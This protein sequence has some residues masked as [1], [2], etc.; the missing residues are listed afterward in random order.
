MVKRRGVWDDTLVSEVIASGAQGIVDLVGS[1]GGAN[2]SGH[3]VDRILVNL[4]AMHFTTPTNDGAQALRYGIAVASAEAFAA[5]V[6]A[7]PNVVTEFPA[8]GWLVRDSC[9]ILQDATEMVPPTICKFDLRGGR[10]L[11]YGNLH[12]VMNNDT[13]FGTAFTLRVVGIVRL[14]VLLP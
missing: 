14:Y 8:G 2:L 6:V 9:T 11:D 3:T 5:G 1:L 12:L 10:K 13:L 7:D 4:Q